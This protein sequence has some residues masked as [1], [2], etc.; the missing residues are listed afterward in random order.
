MPGRDEDAATIAVEAARRAVKH[1]GITRKDI[2]AVYVGSESHPYAVK[3]TAT[4][5]TRR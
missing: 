5:V 4:M 3:P 1:A 2:G